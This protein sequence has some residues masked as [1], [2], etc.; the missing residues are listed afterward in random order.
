MHVNG[1]YGQVAR[2]LYVNEMGIN[3]S[4]FFIPTCM[5]EEWLLIKK[6]WLCVVK[7]GFSLFDLWAL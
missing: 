7:L 1:G 5:V 4:L 6:G 2:Q 3:F